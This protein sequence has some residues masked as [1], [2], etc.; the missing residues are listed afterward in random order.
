MRLINFGICEVVML[1]TKAQYEIEFRCRFESDQ[2]ACKVM[3]FLQP[4]FRREYT[5]FD[6]YHG[7]EF[8]RSGGVLRDSG[9]TDGSQ[10]HFFLG[11]KGPD[12]GC[13]TNLRREYNEETTGSITNSA[14]LR[15]FCRAYGTFTPDQVNKLLEHSGLTIFM[16]YSGH[17]LAGRDDMLGVNTKLMH[18][19]VLRWPILVELEMLASSRVEAQHCQARLEQIKREYHLTE[20]LVKEEPGTLLYQREFGNR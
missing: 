10:R 6:N 12:H 4:S 16:T 18:C 5:W 11:W 20:Y 1:F 19:S 15:H 17:S 8:F 7:L 13:F 2:E 3:P 9:V 14:I